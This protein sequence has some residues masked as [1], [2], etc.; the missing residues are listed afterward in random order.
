MEVNSQPNEAAQLN[1]VTVLEDQIREIYGRAAYSHKTH[2]TMADSLLSK[3]NRL[4]LFEIVLLAVTSGS[5]M[6][7]VFEESRWGVVVGGF[8]SS[9]LL[10]LALYFKDANMSEATCKHTETASKLWGIRES[11]L[12][13]LVDLH[14]GGNPGEIRVRRD[15]LNLALERIYAQAPRTNAAAYKAAQTALKSSEDLFFSDVE[16]N[17]ILPKS[18]RK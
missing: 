12:S 9:A 3:H 11:L 1:Q 14:G 7:A 17:S 18:L 10:A 5:L 6:V 13:L 15:N 2:E 16:L 8:V 4:K